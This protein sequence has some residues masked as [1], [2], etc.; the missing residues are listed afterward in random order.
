MSIDK[1]V[2]GKENVVSL[3]DVTKDKGLKGAAFSKGLY[4]SS[5]MINS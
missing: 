4:N 5:R 2:M 1:T 3:S